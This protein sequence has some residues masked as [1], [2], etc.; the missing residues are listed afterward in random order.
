M[1]V[2]ALVEAASGNSLVEA[3]VEVVALVESL[4]IGV[5]FADVDADVELLDINDCL[6]C[7]CFQS[8]PS[9]WL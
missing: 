7:L 4:A 9:F 8:L 6:E 2:V 5:P 3:V 1:A